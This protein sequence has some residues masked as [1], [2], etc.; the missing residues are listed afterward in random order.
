MNLL[1]VKEKDGRYFS[2]K[3]HTEGEP[4]MKLSGRLSENTGR[5]ARRVRNPTT[6]PT[7]PSGV[8]PGIAASERREASR[9]S[10][11]RARRCLS[12]RRRERLPSP[13][14]PRRSR[15]AS[16]FFRPTRRSTRRVRNFC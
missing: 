13:I 8:V 3:P 14:E 1:Q 10:A 9:R 5:T 15:E 12:A 4:N 7:A 16:F 11:G 6:L 2:P